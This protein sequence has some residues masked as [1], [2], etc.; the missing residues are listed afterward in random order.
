VETKVDSPTMILHSS[1]IY[2]YDVY[3]VTVLLIVYRSKPLRYKYT[4]SSFFIHH[5]HAMLRLKRASLST[6]AISALVLSSSHLLSHS[7]ARRSAKSARWLANAMAP[8]LLA[9]ASSAFVARAMT[10]AS[11]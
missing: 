4:S 10:A 9:T 2:S 5:S 3:E 11:S 7:T 8:L 1:V 6:S